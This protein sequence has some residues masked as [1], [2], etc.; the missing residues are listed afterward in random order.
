MACQVA[1]A[2]PFDNWSAPIT[3]TSSSCRSSARMFMKLHPAAM[4]TTITVNDRVNFDARR[5]GTD[6]A[7]LPA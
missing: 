5:F 7:L 2:M 6:P 4:M 1:L 3:I